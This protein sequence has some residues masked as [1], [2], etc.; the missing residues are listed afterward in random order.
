MTRSFVRRMASA[1][2]AT[3]SL[4]ALCAPLVFAGETIG[5]NKTHLMRLN[6][7]AG[8][9]V[10][11]NPKIADI[12]VHS[13]TTILVFGRGYGTTDIL[14]LDANGNTLVHTDIDVVEASNSKSVR[15]MLPKQD[16]RTYFCNPYCEPA[17]RLGD[18]PDF[19]GNFS[20][21]AVTGAAGTAGISPAQAPQMAGDKAASAMSPSS[22]PNA[23]S[24]RTKGEPNAR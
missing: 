1:S 12:S 20:G 10:V 5:L 22:S 18:A 17:P 21:Q 6:A 15:M 4:A 11:G 14:V 3:A 7:P 9:I 23:Q 13:D 16:N 2:L 24:A 8:A 19:K